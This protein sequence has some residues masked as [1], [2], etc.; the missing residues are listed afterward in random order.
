MKGTSPRNFRAFLYR[1]MQR[2]IEDIKK[3]KYYNRKSVNDNI[4]K[5]LFLFISM[6][7]ASTIIITVIFIFI[8]GLSPFIKDYQIGPDKY[9]VN[10]W[11]FLGG[12][13][14][15]KP[16]NKYHIGFIVLNTLYVCFGAVIISAPISVL[17][18]L[19]IA[20]IAPKSLGKI[21][22]SVIELLAAIPSII[23]GLFG[24]KNITIFVNKI[25]KLTGYQSAGGLSN[26]SAMLVLA[27][28]IIP[29]ITM[30]STEA[31]KAVDPSLIHASLA[32]GASKTQTN[33]KI[34]LKA[35]K[36]GIF[37]GVILGI[38]RVLGEAT[39]VSMVAG[40]AGT[41]PNFH[42][43]ETTRTLTS[44]MLM[45][46]KETVGLDYDI[47]FSVGLVLIII[48]LVSNALLNFIKNKVVKI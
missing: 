15:F 17:T 39:A 8:K 34:V 36:S 37:S 12:N 40:N 41:G 29:T 16:P 48:I 2:Q 20:R 31:I 6:I 18:A 27:I 19:F 7:A 26:L 11:H 24:S 42:P 30:L 44:T 13:M 47:R 32:L 5:Y 4:F 38:G 3:N 28:M 43:F 25:A 45:S 9:R 1:N 46:M 35:A 10:F 23:F 14:W 22:S 21:I 33:F